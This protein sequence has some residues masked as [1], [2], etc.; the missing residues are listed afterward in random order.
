[1]ELN[2]SINNLFYEI[3]KNGSNV[4]LRDP[5]ISDRFHEINSIKNQITLWKS[6]TK[7]TIIF[8][9]LNTIEVLLNG[10]SDEL[11]QIQQGNRV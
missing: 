7:A 3:V 5:F 10:L 6:L 11:I 4:G 1:M 2:D 9:S 8:S